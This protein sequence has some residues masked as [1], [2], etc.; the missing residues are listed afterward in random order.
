M[1]FMVKVIW[2]VEK[3]NELARN[4]DLGKMAQ[5]ILDEIKP[6]AAYF[7]AEGGNRSAI[8]FVNMEDASEIPA[9]AEPW[10]LAVNAT[11]EFQPV[12]KM[13]DLLKAGA[14]IEK[15]VKKFG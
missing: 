3:G 8:L 11:V 7:V 6:E 15:A 10:F 4:G 9:I 12:M 13:E 2:D 1:R 5:S 14:S